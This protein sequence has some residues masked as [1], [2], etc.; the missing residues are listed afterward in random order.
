M[1]SNASVANLHARAKAIRN[2][3]NAS[4]SNMNNMMAR[5]E[6]SELYNSAVNMHNKVNIAEIV[7]NKNALAARMKNAERLQ[8][9]MHWKSGNWNYA[10][11]KLK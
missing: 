4:V 8:E 6:I 3:K 11:P 2:A 5:G 9:L 7:G 1:N 10:N